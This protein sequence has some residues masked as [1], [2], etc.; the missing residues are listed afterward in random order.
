MM[1]INSA[2][3]K[4]SWFAL[5]FL[6]VLTL[7]LFFQNCVQKSQIKTEEILASYNNGGAYEGKPGLFYRFLPNYSCNAS[8]APFASLDMQPENSVLL[9]NEAGVCNSQSETVP[10]LN[11][12]LS[13]FQNKVLGLRSGIYEKPLSWPPPEIVEFWCRDRRDEFGV[14]SIT[15]YNLED[16]SSAVKM[17]YNDFSSGSGVL[18]SPP[19][20]AVSSTTSAVGPLKQTIQ[21]SN[22]FMLTVTMDTMS[23]AGT[24]SGTLRFEHNGDPQWR[25]VFC[26]IGGRF[27]SLI[28]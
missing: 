17:Y 24:V 1:K 16:Q 23:P 7:V 27:D 26:R 25:D 10:T 9:Y 18:Q 6:S 11:L 8:W 20:F 28:P 19:A 2:I 12:D 3:K 15:R 14:E 4:S 5:T 21:A 13:I 22:G